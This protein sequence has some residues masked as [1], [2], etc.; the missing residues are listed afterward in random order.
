VIRDCLVTRAYYVEQAESNCEDKCDHDEL[1]LQEK[2]E[3]E[4]PKF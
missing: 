4:F 3:D 2:Y 1:L